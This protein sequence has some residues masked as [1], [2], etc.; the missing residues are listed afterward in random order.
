MHVAYFDGDEWCAYL[1]DPPSARQ[2]Q[3]VDP[4]TLTLVYYL[5]I[6]DSIRARRAELVRLVDDD[7]MYLRAYFSE[8]DIYVAVRND[9]AER[10]SVNSLVT[11]DASRAV[12]GEAE[13]ATLY[14]LVLSLDAEYSDLQSQ[15]ERESA[16]FFL[17]DDGVAVELGSSWADWAEAGM[18]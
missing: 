2:G 8:T 4:A 3:L 13:A 18:R 6:V 5:P 7:V 10:V 16:H 14:D 1:E 11:A 17:G 15:P 9:I 12:P